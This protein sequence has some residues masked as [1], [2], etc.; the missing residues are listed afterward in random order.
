M[1][2]HTPAVDLRKFRPNLLNTDEFR[3]LKW[4]I[5]WPIYLLIFW[6][7]ERWIHFSY[8]HPMY[9]PIDD[10]IP[11]CEWFVIPYM[12][13][14]LYLAGIHLYAMI[15][16]PTTLVRLIRFLIITHTVTMLIYFL[17]PTCQE[18]RPTHFERDNILTRFMAAF[19]AFDTNTNVCPSIHVID[20]IAVL[21]AAWHSDNLGSVGW[22]VFFVVSTTLISVSTVF[23]KQHSILD[24]LAALPLCAV[25]WVIVFPRKRRRGSGDTPKKSE[26]PRQKL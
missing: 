7:A 18:L 12:F 8:Y 19:Y 16:E 5:F 17:Y 2:K 10:L 23:L 13:W 14:F 24:V 22:R 1:A 21:G 4:L 26:K 15:Y 20:S 6:A 11:F 9:S 25:A 3:H